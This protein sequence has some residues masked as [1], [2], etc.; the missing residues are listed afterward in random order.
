MQWALKT[1]FIS[2]FF[3]LATLDAQ[4]TGSVSWSNQGQRESSAVIYLNRNNGP[5]NN[6][7]PNRWG[8][9]NYYFTNYGYPSGYGWY[10]RDRPYYSSYYYNRASSHRGFTYPSYPYDGTYYRNNSPY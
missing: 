2:S 7:Y 1:L 5:H 10:G 4:P 6:N 3:L 8:N 9:N